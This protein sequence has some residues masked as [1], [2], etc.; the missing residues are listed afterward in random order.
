VVADAHDGPVVGA[1][2][3]LRIDAR[4]LLRDQA[5]LAR[6][7]AVAVVPERDGT[8][9][10]ERPAAVAHGLDVALEALGRGLDAESAGSGDDDRH[11][12]DRNSGD[13]GEERRGVHAL[14]PDPDHAR[15]A[16]RTRVRDVDVVA[17]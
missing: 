16:A 12:G 3:E 2:G 13:A 17:A 14:L 1:H 5:V 11:A 9:V 8:E 7:L 6:A 15:L 4:D 10:E